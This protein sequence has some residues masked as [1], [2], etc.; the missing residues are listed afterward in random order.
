MGFPFL[1]PLKE[2]TTKKL[3]AR[4]KNKEALN[5]LMPFVVLSSA[6]VV[7]NTPKNT[8]EIKAIYSSGNYDSFSYKGCV[9][10]NSTDIL[11]NYQLGK[12]LAGYDLDGKPIEVEGEKNR[13]VSMP[14]IESVEIDTDGGNNTL[15]TAQIKIRVF[16]LKQLEMFELFFLRP[17]MRVVLEYGWNVGIREKLNLDIA[18][19]MFANKSHTRYLQKYSDI[20]SREDNAYKTAKNAYIK[21]LK[22]T[23][24]NYDFMAGQVSNFSYSPQSDGT[25]DVSLEISAGNELQL[26]MPVKQSK[27]SDKSDAKSDAKQERPYQT[28]VNKLAAE[29]NNPKFVQELGNESEWI[30]EFFNWGAINVTQKDTTFSKDPYISMKL[31]LHLLNRMKI[32][33]ESKETIR[34]LYFEDE[35]GTKPIIHVSSNYLIIS[36]TRD[37]ILPG[38]LPAILVSKDDKNKDV[39][40][41]DPKAEKENALIDN[42]KFNVSDAKEIT[43]YPIYDVLGNGILTKSSIGNLLN[44]YFKYDT[45]LSAYNGAY[46]SADIVNSLLDTINSNMYGLCKL[47]LQAESDTPGSPLVIIDRKLNIPQPKEKIQEIFRFKVG[48]QNSI[49]K[50]FNFNMELSTLMQAQA[51][52]SSQLAIQSATN[53]DK[54]N[55]GSKV[56]V[57]DPYQHANLSYAKNSDDFYSINALE[58]QIVKQANRWNK[59]IEETANVSKEDP[60]KKDGEEEAQNLAEVRN[61]NYI[62]FKQNPDSKTEN[63]KN[64]IYTDAALI[65]SYIN[66]TDVKK[67]GTALTYLDISLVIDGIAGISCGEYFHIDGVP[68]IYNKNGYFQVTN[69]KQGISNAGWQTTIEAGYRIN[70]TEE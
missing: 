17:S 44:V 28:W 19:K 49:V 13:R 67:Q 2:W 18:T 47:E 26:W 21:T 57:N 46:T 15:K 43:D 48:A 40:K 38:K 42:K 8:D 33:S 10:A 20:F 55:N 39:I 52:Y 61:K 22:E 68:E 50:E 54:S 41:L 30:G 14:I 60:K 64:Y 53:K 11:K 5:T 69:V 45:F 36:P 51:L 31:I 59:I 6:A 35:A 37:F 1:A 24:G 23:N 62:R 65:Q 70:I 7:T 29:L 25:F 12:T 3:E 63:P 32:F 56:P 66:P 9:I 58:I 16:T 4:E 34:T 27:D